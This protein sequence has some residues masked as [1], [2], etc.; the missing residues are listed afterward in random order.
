MY[1]VG[2]EEVEAVR[3]VLE[4]GKVFRYGIGAQCSRF[5]ERYAEFLGT[6]FCLQTASGTNALTAALIGAQIGPGDEVIVPAC[7]YMATP[8]AVLAAGAI[9]VIVDINESIGIDPQ[10]FEAAV[11]PRTR[12]VIPVHMWGL[13]CDMDE[14]MKIAGRHNIL[15]IE[16][17]CQGVGG[18]YVGSGGKAMLG[19]IGTVGAFSFNY[20]K[21]MTCG[22]GGA[23]VTN[24]ERIAERAM[25]VID[26]C[27]FYWDGRENTFAGFVSNGARAS[28]IEG[29]ILNVQLDR[30]PGMIE[31]MQA[32]QRTIL[33][34]TVGPQS[35][36]PLRRAPFNGA[37]GGCATHTMYQFDDAAAADAFA[38]S[39]GGTVLIKTGRHVYTEWD[40]VLDHRGGPHPALNPY[41]MEAN[42]ECRMDYDREMC[43]R[44]LDILSRTVSVQSHPEH[45]Q[46]DTDALV[47]RILAAAKQPAVS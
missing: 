26:P 11:G 47:D 35:G 8:I 13:P 20:Y 12:A 1:T 17:A 29:A 23:V 32:E 46:A 19:S 37:E 6:R 5:E 34:R 28:E 7:T 42:R 39:V 10:A 18:Y 25:C 43:R 9:P 38:E 22:E 16:D 45:T 41:E 31:R 44:S 3:E 14:L 2:R 30:I 33:A 24:D 4:G 15:V 36:T 40:P 21:N 27:R